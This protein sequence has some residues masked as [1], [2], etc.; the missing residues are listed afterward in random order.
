MKNLLPLFVILS[1]LIGCSSSSKQLEKGDYDAA[2]EKS[3]KKINRDPGKFEEVDVFND[4]YRM[5]Y[6]KDH[7]QVMRLKKAGNPANWVKVYNLYKHMNKRQE[8]A[9]SLPSVGVI[10]YEEQD[11]GPEIQNAKTKATEYAY[12]KGTELLA[13]NDKLKAREAY[14]KFMEVQQLTPDFRDVKERMVDAKLK[15]TTNVFFTIEDQSNTLVPKQ[16]MADLQAIDVNDLDKNWLNYDNQIDSNLIYHY[17]V[18]LTM[19]E[20]L[21]SPE[22]LKETNSRN[23]KKVEDGF[24][25]VLDENG[26]VKKD[27]L[28]NDIKITRYKTIFCG[29]KRVHQRKTARISG[30]INYF[31]NLTNKL[32]KSEPITSDA[33]FE[34]FY[35]TANGDIAALTPEVLKELDSQPAPFPPSEVLVMQ[36]GDVLKGM[37]KEIMVKNKAYLK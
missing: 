8:L 21:V 29:V 7:E 28:G 24:D 10:V 1:V 3:A 16:L 15:G 2:M 35:A 6:L 11:Y 33:L 37:T 26:N 32:M 13:T 22:E 27:T 17:S 18:I 30:S 25:Y 9:Q 12:A 34:H 14:G 31:D 4:A 20:I 36:A 23:S 19:T 5:A